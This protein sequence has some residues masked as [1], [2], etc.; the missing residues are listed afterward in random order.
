[1]NKRLLRMVREEKP[2]VGEIRWVD[3]FVLTSLSPDTPCDGVHPFCSHV[4]T[5]AWAAAAQPAAAA[6]S[7]SNLVDRETTVVSLAQVC[8]PVQPVH[9]FMSK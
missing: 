7:P 6:V 4:Y 8:F 1:V 3:A 5:T 9:M 2:S